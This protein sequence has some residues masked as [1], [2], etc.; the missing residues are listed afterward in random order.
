[1]TDRHLNLFYTYNQDSQLIENNLTR[2][3]IVSLSF[4]SGPARDAWMRLL[5]QDPLA[6]IGQ[7]IDVL[8]CFTNANFALQSWMHPNLTRN[9]PQ[10]YLLTIAGDML[11]ISD[12]E[13]DV[14]ESVPDA[15]IY[16]LEAGYCLLVE[17]KLNG[18]P[19]DERQVLAHAKQWL[20]LSAKALKSRLLAVS[21]LDVIRS[22]NELVITYPL[23]EQEERILVH[24]TE[25]LAFYG[26][27]VFSGFNFLGLEQPPKMEL[28][29]PR[30][31]IHFQDMPQAPIFHLSQPV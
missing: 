27:R 6:Q 28:G 7:S 15:W 11:E 9:I 31:L 24:L 23:N 21:W 30:A 20:G 25:Y 16:D 22:I 13:T 12:E 5:L 14:Y 4:L 17:A 2:A 3:W 10:P 19:L 26:Y 8:G 18:N 29:S 1:M